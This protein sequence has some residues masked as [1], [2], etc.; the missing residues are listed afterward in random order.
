MRVLLRQF[1]LPGESQ[2]VERIVETFGVTY[3]GQNR[4]GGI[5]LNSDA[6]Y[7]FSYLLMML[8]SNLHNPQVLDKMTLPQFSNLSKNMNGPN[9]EFP[10]DFLETVYASVQRTP[11]GVH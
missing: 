6:V 10:A 4:E 1:T 5:F 11:L 2:V 8:Q 9:S 3:F 7:S